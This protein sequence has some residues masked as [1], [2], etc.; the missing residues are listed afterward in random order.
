MLHIDLLSDC[1]RTFLTDNMKWVKRHDERAISIETRNGV[2]WFTD[3]TKP[4][5]ALCFHKLSGIANRI[6]QAL[7][8]LKGAPLNDAPKFERY[9]VAIEIE[10]LFW[11]RLFL[12]RVKCRTILH[13]RLEADAVYVGVHL[14]F[15]ECCHGRPC[16]IGH[17]FACREARTAPR[18]AINLITARRLGCGRRALGDRT[19]SRPHFSPAGKLCF[20]LKSDIRASLLIGGNA[21][22]I[23]NCRSAEILADMRDDNEGAFTP[24]TGI[25][26]W[27]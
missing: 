10:D 26:H 8:L 11:L 2:P 22:S 23:S 5:W 9:F 6:V 14:V 17:G 18:I 12:R 25:R 7:Q 4:V 21:P 24:T 1:A 16:R 15:G 19:T 3:E 27:H 20:R 13:K